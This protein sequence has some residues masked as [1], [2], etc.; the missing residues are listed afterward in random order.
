MKS[1]A[2]YRGICG[3]LLFFLVWE[4]AVRS[5]FAAYDYLPAPT[6]ILASALP[7]VVQGDLLPATA[8]T[9]AVAL[10]G[11]AIAGVIGTCLGVLLGLSKIAR[12]YLMISIE[13]LRPLP[14][15]ALVPLA[16]LLFGFSAET[17]LFVIILP[18]I[19]PLLVNVKAG[20]IA[21]PTS[22]R[23]VSRALRLGKFE[24]IVKIYIPGA[25]EFFLVGCRLSLTTALVLAIVTEMIG[26]PE[27]LGYAVVRE[28]QALNPT[29]MFVYVLTTGLLGICFNLMLVGISRMILPGIFMRPARAGNGP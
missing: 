27:G 29:A 9:V 21:V 1:A 7:L 12:D 2:S 17:E 8:H 18:S 10:F 26:N 5:G 25:A 3:L 24:A 19:W 14:A 22:L 20:I 15:V 13:V 28:A 4:L 6:A 23:D 11:W 16:L